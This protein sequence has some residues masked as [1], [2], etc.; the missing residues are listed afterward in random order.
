MLGGVCAE[1][2][3]ASRC[4]LVTYIAVE[5][6]HRG[7]GVART[8]MREVSDRFGA[9]ARDQAAPLHAVFAEAEDPAKVDPG[10]RAT[11]LRERRDGPTGPRATDRGVGRP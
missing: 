10:L 5:R 7:L 11:A 1:R 2:Y 9:A 6:Q 8:L 3:R 4:G